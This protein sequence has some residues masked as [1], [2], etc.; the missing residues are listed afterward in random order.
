MPNLQKR[1]ASEAHIQHHRSRGS[2]SPAV[3]EGERDSCRCRRLLLA[4][5]L[6]PYSVRRRYEGRTLLL[7]VQK[8]G[9]PTL[10]MAGS[11]AETRPNDSMYYLRY[12]TAS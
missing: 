10:G 1:R 9:E 12:C 7:H 6:S 8:H 3:T 4:W 11:R 2:R 5:L